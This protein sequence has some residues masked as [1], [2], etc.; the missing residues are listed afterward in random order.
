MNWL[1]FIKLL[2][3]QK[4][5]SNSWLAILG[6]IAII[7]SFWDDFGKKKNTSNIKIVLSILLGGII[8]F[9]TIKK[10]S[11]DSIKER[12]ESNKV[13]SLT[14]NISY[15][16]KENKNVSNKLDLT[17]IYL[18]RLDSIGIKRDSIRNQPIIQKSIV[19]YI[20][21]VNNIYQ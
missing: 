13:D 12:K 9:I 7:L 5:I 14:I 18:K 3:P 11:Q 20:D 2:F 17:H 19:N 16:R 1:I 15:L 21:K 4:M 6:F 8:L 10:N